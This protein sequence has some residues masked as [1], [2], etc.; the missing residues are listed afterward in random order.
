[1]KWIEM[2]K[3]A[4]K[5][6]ETCT[7]IKSGE[8]V[9]IVCNPATTEIAT[10]LSCA[11]YERNAEPEII[12]MLPR[13]MDGQEPP[14][15]IA[16]AMKE[17]N[18]VFTPVTKSI[19]HT[20]AV[21]EA[22]RAGARILVMSA[23][24]D[25]QMLSGGIEADFE[26][27]APIC[28]RIAKLLTDAKVI[29]I[30]TP[31]GTD[32]KADI[33][34]RFGRA[35]TGMAD[36]PG[37]FSTAITIEANVGPIEGSS[38]GIIVADASVPYLGIGVLE[39]PIKCKVESG[40]I[41]NIQGGKEAQ[42]LKKNWE[43]FNDPNV[44]NIAEIGIGLNPKAKMIGLMLEDEGVCGSLHIGVGTNITFG[45]KI[46]T[47]THYDLLMWGYTLE[48][49][50]KVVIEKGDLRK[51]DANTFERQKES[52]SQPN[53]KLGSQGKTYKH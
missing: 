28:R 36:R 33:D 3:G 7:K 34:G 13:Q 37:Q 46:K 26:R 30:T 40:Y 19:T 38:E 14:K 2:I 11:S 5:L 44:Y 41:T 48:L 25:D 22:T 15:P 10:V 24:S 6:V 20:T 1:M 16:A 47:A 45:G 4:R 17:A 21:Q 12:I 52:R 43:S 18:V 32:L 50:G 51:L 31:A 29:R 23:F 8:D 49:D 39:E 9:L 27:Q 35:L 53:L 42:I